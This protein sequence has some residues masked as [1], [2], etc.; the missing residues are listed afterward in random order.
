MENNME[1]NVETTQKK[2][3]KVGLVIAIVVVCVLMIVGGI[4]AVKYFQAMSE[5][6]MSAMSDMAGTNEA[7]YEVK[8]EDIEQEI[9]TSGT[10]I[11][12]EKD[13]YVSPVTTKVEEIH[14]EVGQ[15]VKKGDV[16]LTYD[17]TDLGDDLARVQLQAQS[18][19]AAGNESYE[20]ASEA[21]GKVSAAKAEIKTLKKEIKELKSDIKDLTKQIAAYEEKIQA[22]NAGKSEEE[23][24]PTAGLSEK[25][26]KKYQKA[27]TNLE[28]KNTSLST[29]QGELAKQEAIVEANQDIKV[30]ESTKAQISASNQLSDM[31]VNDAQESVDAAEAGIVATED[32]IV[33]SVEIVKGS[34]AN[35]TQTLMTIIQ[36]DQIGAEFAISKDDLG[37]IKKGQKARVV[38][39]NREYE[40]T[41]QYISRVATT[42]GNLLGNS[43]SGASIRGRVILDN[44]D[45]EIF[46]GVSAKVYI[47]VG[48]AEQAFVIPYAALCSDIDGDYV[49]VVNEN[50][51]IERKDITIGI[52]SN[53]YYEVL[54]GLKEGDKVIRNVTKDMKPGD[55]YTDSMA[56]MTAQ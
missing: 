19:R 5:E 46:I 28:K 39:G 38:V 12:L 30:S 7:I 3:P 31:S 51:I 43:A 4:A 23:T 52:F 25:E 6:M 56:I 48:S 11:G 42:E 15:T 32:G 41:V 8:R 45:D 47:F 34:Y 18:E 44:P 10:V 49:Y 21:A 37:S 29:K 55:E 36:A 14:V 9:T 26:V 24:N 1:H 50:N 35:E 20:V 33:E 2:K 40:G 13:A 53:E 54:E 22:A 17:T 16:L 27:L